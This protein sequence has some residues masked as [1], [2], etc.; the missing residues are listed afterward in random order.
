MD[1]RRFLGAVVVSSA[2]A[3][4]SPALAQGSSDTD[5]EVIS[6]LPPLPADLEAYANE[7][8]APYIESS[9]TGTAPP[10]QDEIRRAYDILFSSPLGTAPVDVAQ[11]FLAVAGGAYGEAARPFT[12]EWP[13]RANPMIYH[14][15]FG[16]PY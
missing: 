10:T 13:V 9:L 7:P 4:S 2:I 3:R 16:H 5:I 15:F 11:Y 1:R 14:F 6:S 8:P 12:R